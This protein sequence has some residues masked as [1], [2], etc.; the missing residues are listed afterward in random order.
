MKVHVH[1]APPL[2]KARFDAGDVFD[3]TNALIA[4][5]EICSALIPG[6]R[7]ILDFGTVRSIDSGSVARRA[8]SDSASASVSARPCSERSGRR[9]SWS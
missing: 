9:P 7:L 5:E 4:R 1:A 8:R 3:H 6:G 2:V